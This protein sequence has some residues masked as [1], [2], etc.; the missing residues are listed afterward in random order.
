MISLDN[1]Y[2]EKDLND[3][4]ERVIKNI[5]DNNILNIEYC[6]EFKFD[7]LGVELIYKN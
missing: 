2:N 3:F 5:D 7:G 1:T 6:L 4:N